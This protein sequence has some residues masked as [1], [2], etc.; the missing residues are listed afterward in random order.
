MKFINYMSERNSKFGQLKLKQA[1]YSKGNCVELQLL[2]PDKFGSLTEQE[3][4]EILNYANEFVENKYNITIKYKKSYVDEEVVWAF[5]KQFL[6]EN[7]KFADNLLSKNSIVVKKIDESLAT[8]QNENYDNYELIIK[9]S[10]SLYTYFKEDLIHKLVNY[11]QANICANFTI[12]IDPTGTEED[13][14]KVLKDN[15]N[16]QTELDYLRDVSIKEED[17]Y[18][19]F[20]LKEELIGQ[21]PE[22]YAIRLDQIHSDNGKSIIAGTI[23]FFN[24]K[25]YP[26]KK[27]ETKEKTMYTLTVEDYW[28]K[29]RCVYFTNQNAIEQMQKL[30]EGDQVAIMGDYDTYNGNSSFI[31]NS[32]A[33]ANLLEKPEENIEWRK[34]FNEY[35]VVKPEEYIEMSQLSLLKEEEKEVSEFLQQNDI[36]VFDFETTGLNVDDSYILELGAV[37]IHKGKLTETFETLVKPPVKIPKEISELTHITEDMVANAPTY[38]L[39]LADFYKFTRGCILSAYN[40]D[41][42]AKFLE[43]Y[44]R[45]ILFNFDNEKIDTLVLARQ[46]IKGLPNYKLKTVVTHLNVELVSAHRALDDA[47]ACAKVFQ[48]L[49]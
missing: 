9:M 15:D 8:Q 45:S 11:L 24:E 19:P 38:E 35:L 43:K 4:E 40:I 37:K 1:I 46:K 17:K 5:L 34:P 36:V 20:E 21:I 48:K 27:D 26:D 3:K 29:M 30:K 16:R 41:F 13:L 6:E 47:V 33:Y 14:Q 7:L 42:D 2:F 12:T 39:V 10:K 18:Y 22:N 32:I 23:K 28:G 25:K 31:I 49:M 44:G